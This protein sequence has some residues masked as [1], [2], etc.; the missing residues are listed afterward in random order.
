MD[1]ARLQALETIDPWP[2]PPWQTPAFVEID[3]EPDRDKAKAKA[4]AR[5][6]DTSITV[7]SDA[8]GQ[9][10]HLGAAAVALDPDHKVTQYRKFCIGSMEYWSVYAAELMAIY[11]ATSLVPQDLNTTLLP[12]KLPLW[13]IFGC[14]ELPHPRCIVGAQ[15]ERILSVPST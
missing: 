3:I 7:F 4:S 13:T 1:L 9:H 5:Q 8:S 14:M 6:K 2:Q 12:A 15:H 10:N 11:Y